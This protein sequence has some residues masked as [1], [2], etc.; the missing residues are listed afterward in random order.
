MSRLV[1]DLLT[2]ARADA[3]QVIER[4]C[5]DPVPILEDVRR[6]A[7]RLYPD[8]QVNLILEPGIAPGAVAIAGD[9]AALRQLLWILLENALV[10]GGPSARVWLCLG[11]SDTYALLRV[12]DDGPGLPQSDLDRVFERFYQADPSRSGGG[13]GLGLA[14]ARWIAE[15]HGGRIWARNNDGPGASFF[16]ALP[17]AEGARPTGPEC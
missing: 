10:H 8:R 4:A 11:V 2:L 15:A 7:A 6:Q 5:L 16:V 3:G 17:L 14:I 12:A 13:A 9:A 1:H